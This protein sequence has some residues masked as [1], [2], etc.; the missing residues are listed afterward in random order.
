[1][2]PEGLEPLRSASV[3]REIYSLNCKVCSAETS[4][5]QVPYTHEIY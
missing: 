4:K 3:N 1:M 2:D 5:K